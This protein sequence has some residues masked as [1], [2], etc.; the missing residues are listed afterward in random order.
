[1]GHVG[2]LS[3]GQRPRRCSRSPG[4]PP[5]GCPSRSPGQHRGL[6]RHLHVAP[7][8]SRAPGR[9]EERTGWAGA[10]WAPVHCATGCRSPLRL[11]WET[12]KKELTPRVFLE[13]EVTRDRAPNATAMYVVARGHTP[14][15][16]HMVAAA[17]TPWHESAGT[18]VTKHRRPGARTAGIHVPPP[19]F[20]RLEVQTTV[21]AGGEGGCF[22]RELPPGCRW[23]LPAVR[24]QARTESSLGAP[25]RCCPTSSG[26][27]WTSFDPSDFPEAS[28]PATVTPR[29]WG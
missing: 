22:R 23:P 2:R 12:G 6:T 18:C 4:P 20:W 9:G 29:H 27:H 1:M 11:V 5:R 10:A 26:P 13:G 17:K 3:E 28:S 19:R 21:S 25:L 14:Q 16:V 15:G 24:S 8:R 7:P